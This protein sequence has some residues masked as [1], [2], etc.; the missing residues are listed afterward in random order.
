MYYTWK[1]YTRNTEGNEISPSIGH[2][3][4]KRFKKSGETVQKR[5]K[6]NTVVSLGQSLF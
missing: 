3:I 1:V 2:N 4:I 6:K 5:Q